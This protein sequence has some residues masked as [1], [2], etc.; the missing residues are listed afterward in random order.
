MLPALCHGVDSA[1]FVCKA[2]SEPRARTSSVVCEVVLPLLCSI[3]FGVAA[4]VCYN[5]DRVGLGKV[6]IVGIVGC[7]VRA[8]YGCCRSCEAESGYD[9]EEV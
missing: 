2:C 7:Y 5:M 3:A 8:L 9:I 6:M 1:L 4:S